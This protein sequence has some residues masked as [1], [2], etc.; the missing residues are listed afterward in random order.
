MRIPF[1][2]EFIFFLEKSRK[3]IDFNIFCIKHISAHISMHMYK[4]RFKLWGKKKNEKFKLF[5]KKFF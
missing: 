3:N 4:H 5:F 2:S 1:F